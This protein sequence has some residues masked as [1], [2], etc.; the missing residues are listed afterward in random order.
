MRRK[1][2]YVLSF[3]CNGVH[4]KNIFFKNHWPFESVAFYQMRYRKASTL[5][6]V[7]GNSIAKR[8]RS[9]VCL[10]IM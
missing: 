10:S 9:C 3:Q 1:I 6:R 5:E 2:I 7:N 4:S 8:Y